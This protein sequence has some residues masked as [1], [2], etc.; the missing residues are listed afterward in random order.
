MNT[1]V[2]VF[3]GVGGRGSILTATTSSDSH[4]LTPSQRQPLAAL[5]QYQLALTAVVCNRSDELCAPASCDFLFAANPAGNCGCLSS[6]RADMTALNSV[7]CH[8]RL[9]CFVAL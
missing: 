3:E 1:K 4:Y 6:S 2:D 7:N 5:Q 9:P 8:V